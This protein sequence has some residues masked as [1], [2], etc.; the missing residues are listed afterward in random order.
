[1]KPNALVRLAAFCLPLIA[2]SHLPAQEGK[3]TPPP[4]D[5]PPRERRDDAPP[6]E[7]G[8]RG[9]GEN[10]RRS[11]PPAERGQ[12]GSRERPEQRGRQPETRRVPFIGVL[13]APLSVDARAHLKLAE[14]FGLRVVEVLPESPAKAAGLKEDDI[15]IRFEDQRLASM[16]Q[17]QALVRERR[18]GERVALTVISAGEQREVGVEIG[19]N[20]VPARIEQGPPG[21]RLAPPPPGGRFPDSPPREGRPRPESPWRDWGH[22]LGRQM[23]EWREK[24]EQHQK[25]WREW[26]ERV[27]EWT[28]EHGRHF[29]PP[30]SMPGMPDFSR[31]EQPP[32][33]QTGRIEDRREERREASTITRSDE[34]GIYTLKREGDRVIFSATPRDGEQRSWN[35]NDERERRE[36]PEP[37]RDKLRQLEELRRDSQGAPPFGGEFREDEGNRPPPERRSSSS[38]PR[39]RP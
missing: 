37:L 7:R 11:E 24:L 21:P 12:P 4:A 31:R 10:P 18:A 23:N 22:D 2:A 17:L 39:D 6:P 30:P 36:I 15:L 3:S 34:S 25:A 29:P 16:E 28:H 33:A 14:G 32:E 9:P 35:L 26:Q 20:T 27:R 1:M 19:E 5:G 38:G 8:R 13:T